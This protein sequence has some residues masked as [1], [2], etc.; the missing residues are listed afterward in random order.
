MQWLSDW[1][2]ELSHYSR[3]Y[4]SLISLSL[5]AVFLVLLGKSV[6]HWNDRW[7]GRFPG[8]LQLPVR[9]TVNLLVFG[10]MLFY[11]PNWLEQLF[12]LF[13]NLT[14][15]PVMLIIILLSGAASKRFG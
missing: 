8:F 5:V 10:A 6:I 14:L 4:L 3:D 7:I 11:F 12:N 9:S 15:A 1:V 2:V 13:N